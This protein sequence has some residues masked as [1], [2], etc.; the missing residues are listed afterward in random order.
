MLDACSGNEFAGDDT[1]GEVNGYTGG[2]RGA[3]DGGD[4]A[5]VVDVFWRGPRGGATRRIN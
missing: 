2:R 1:P 3:R 5:E 4:A